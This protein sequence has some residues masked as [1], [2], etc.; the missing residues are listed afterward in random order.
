M[1]DYAGK[2]ARTQEAQASTPSRQSYHASLSALRRRIDRGARR[3]VSTGSVRARRSCPLHL[4]RDLS[5]GEG[6][7]H[8]RG[9]GG[10]S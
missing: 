8:H 2:R 4:A 10:R 5:D 3:D 9:P 6:R 1:S 7:R